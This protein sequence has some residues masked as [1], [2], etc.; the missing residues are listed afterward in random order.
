VSDQVIIGI[1]GAGV[2][3]ASRRPLHG[4]DSADRSIL[5]SG[6]LE[7]RM[8][9]D[10]ETVPC[11]LCPHDVDEHDERAR[12]VEVDCQCGWEVNPW[13]AILSHKVRGQEMNKTLRQDG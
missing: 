1:T 9:L 10:R 12:C 4:L 8:T 3:H 11:W 6:C 2:R 13:Q 5:R 7:I